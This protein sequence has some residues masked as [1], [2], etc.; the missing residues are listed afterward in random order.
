M[1]TRKTVDVYHIVTNYGYGWETEC[2]ESTLK[3]AK[4]TAKEY[5]ENTN[6]T[7]KIVKKREAK[8]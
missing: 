2:T 7:V 6:A 4:K 8:Q 3:E 1:Y 5:R